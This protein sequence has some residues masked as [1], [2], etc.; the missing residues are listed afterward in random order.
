MIVS[1][2]RVVEYELIFVN[3]GS[4]DKTLEVMRRLAKEDDHVTYISFSIF[5]KFWKRNS[6]VC[7]ILQ[8]ERGLYC[9]AGCRYTQSCFIQ[10]GNV[11]V[12]RHN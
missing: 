4:T 2:E 1:R 10:S 7:G 5:K 3:D 12:R 9:S 8:C 11:F 6:Y